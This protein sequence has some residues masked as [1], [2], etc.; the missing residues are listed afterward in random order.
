MDK[1]TLSMI[2]REPLGVVGLIVPWNVPLGLGVAK[3]APALAVGD[4]IVLK[5]SSEACLSMLEM[6]KILSEVLP[7]GTFNVINGRGS[8]TGQYLLDHPAITKFSFTG[9]TEVGY[10]VADA[11]AK[12]LIPATLE[13]GGKS[14]NIFFPDCP[15]EKAVEGAALAILK[16]AGQICFSGSRAL[17]HEE[18]YDE[19]LSQVTA[20]FEKIKVGIPWEKETMMGPVINESQLKKILA[21]VKAGQ[22]EGGRLVCGGSRVQENGLGKGFFIRPTIFAD[23]DNKMKIAREEISA[24]SSRSSSSRMRKRLSAL[25]MIAITAW[26]GESGR[27]TSTALCALRGR[28]VRAACGSTITGPCR[29]TRLSGATR[30]PGSVGNTTKWSSTTFPRSRTLS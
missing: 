26:A 9:S 22:D 8:T 11:A 19:F 2:T 17:V 20:L 24:R 15:W 23:V 27:A 25:P 14:A 4:T 18:I 21:Y 6:T 16:H 13:L 10:L 29:C 12:K 1:D 28:S 5:S 3:I 7:A 30:N